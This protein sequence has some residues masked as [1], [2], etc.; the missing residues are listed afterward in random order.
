MASF[1]YIT[2]AGQIGHDVELKYAHETPVV[3][4]RVATQE[5]WLD[6]KGK[7]R[8]RTDWH[9]IEYFGSHAKALVEQVKI[10][11][12]DSV[13][14]AGRMVYGRYRNKDGVEIP[15]AKIR[16]AEMQLLRRASENTQPSSQ[17]SDDIPD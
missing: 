16:A 9:Q 12:G 17:L 2:V 11:K 8:K 5:E 3:N 4:L 14:A 7:L 10:K 1:N 15:T 6:D 13:L